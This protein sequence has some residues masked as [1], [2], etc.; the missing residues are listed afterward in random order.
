MR[1]CFILDE[2]GMVKNA[3]EQYLRDIGY[4][5]HAFNVLVSSKIGLIRDVPDTRYKLYASKTFYFKR[6][7]IESILF[8]MFQR[9]LSGGTVTDHVNHY[10]LL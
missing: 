4:K 6:T 10:L 1:K 7:E 5:R 3:E 8:Q 2:F 9:K